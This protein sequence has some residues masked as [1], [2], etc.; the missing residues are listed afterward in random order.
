MDRLTSSRPTASVLLF[1]L[2]VKQGAGV[3]P[4]CD[5]QE[6]YELYSPVVGNLI[7]RVTGQLNSP[8]I[9][10]MD[11]NALKNVTQRVE[12]FLEGCTA[13]NNEDLKK[14]IRALQLARDSLCGS[15]LEED[16][17]L[18]QDCFNANVFAEC[19]K[20]GEERLRKLEQGRRSWKLQE[21]LSAE[22]SRWA[23]ECALQA[24][25][26]CPEKAERARKAVENYINLLMDVKMCRRPTEYACE[27]DLF[28]HCYWKV[29][30]GTAGR[31]PLTSE[32]C[33]YALQILQSREIRAYLHKETCKIEQCPKE[34]KRNH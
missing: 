4:E 28:D 15:E 30:R 7:F 18:W 23:S 31:L 5:F 10:E 21:I 2:L 22:T 9:L 25:A 27:G 17:N 1:V 33:R 6:F 19:K 16:L 14:R 20:N 26:G 13:D 8:H 11:C 24:G 32:R 12:T 3:Q 29:L 34:K